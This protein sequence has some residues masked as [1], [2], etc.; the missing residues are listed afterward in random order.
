[1]AK[2]Q[3]VAEGTVEEIIGTGGAV[4]L[5]VQ[6]DPDRAEQVLVGLGATVERADEGLVVE[7]G[8]LSRATAVAALVEAGVGVDQV[9]PRRRLEDAFLSLVGES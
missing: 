6:G 1:M 9:T 2:G 8:E 7:L 4:L 5:V 3:K